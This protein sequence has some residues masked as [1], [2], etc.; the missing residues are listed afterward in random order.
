MRYDSKSENKPLIV[1]APQ[2]I[3]TDTTT[4]GV[5]IDTAGYNSCDI[6]LT[7]G[8]IAAGDF[9][10]LVQE[11]DTSGSGY[12]DVADT[13]L[14]GTE[15]A[16][17]LITTTTISSIGYVGKKRYI[18]VSVVSANSANATVGVIA[19]LSKGNVPVV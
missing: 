17:K 14:S 5:E 3:S 7:S 2:T 4:A 18:K 11:S 13:F 19:V 16:A 15:A 10:P 12:T 6:I 9:T 1:L 8:T